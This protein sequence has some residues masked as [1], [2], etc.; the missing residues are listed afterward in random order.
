[1]EQNKLEIHVVYS[2]AIQCLQIDIDMTHPFRQ[3]T[4]KYVFRL[5]QVL[6]SNKRSLS[7]AVITQ[8]IELND[9]VITYTKKKSYKKL[10]DLD[11]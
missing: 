1:M 10:E 6:I 9:S 7:K 5:Y 8:L 3:Y 2:I 4:Y 11:I